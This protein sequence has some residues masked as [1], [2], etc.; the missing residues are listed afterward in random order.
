MFPEDSFR[1]NYD[2][3][4]GICGSEGLEKRA[5]SLLYQSCH[6][7]LACFA[8]SSASMARPIVA[9]ILFRRFSGLA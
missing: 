4:D 5:L 9:Q 1:E 8:C 2:V 3:G 7:S 6:L